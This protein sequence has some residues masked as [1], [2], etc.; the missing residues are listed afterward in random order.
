MRRLDLHMRDNETLDTVVRAVRAAEPVDY[1]VVRPEQKD[2]A[3]V[4]VFLPSFSLQYTLSS[5]GLPI[6]IA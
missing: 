4:S 2:R 5:P 6:H 3:L 1:Y